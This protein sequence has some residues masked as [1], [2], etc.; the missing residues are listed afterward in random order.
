MAKELDVRGIF[1]P[2]SSAEEVQEAHRGIYELM[3]QDVM[4]PIVGME[5]AMHEAAVAH[6]EVMAPSQ[7]GATGNIVVLVA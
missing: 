3:S 1:S 6:R 2:V 4:V 5:V 7:G